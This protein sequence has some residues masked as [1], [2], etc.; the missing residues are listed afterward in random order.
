MKKLNKK[1]FTLIELIVVIAILAILAAILI[2][3]VTGY[4]SKATNAKDDANC[5]SL[6]SQ[7]SM[8][9]MIS[10]TATATLADGDTDSKSG[11]TV[12]YAVDTSEGRTITAFSCTTGASRLITIK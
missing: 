2:P 9:L 7:T 12:D 1:G 8:E 6:Y 10:A 3:A 11:L 5:R 4:I